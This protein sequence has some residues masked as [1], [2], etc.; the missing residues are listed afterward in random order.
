MISLEWKTAWCNLYLYSAV[1]QC[2][3][4]SCYLLLLNAVFPCAGT[5]GRRRRGG[6][7]IHLR[8]L[9]DDGKEQLATWR[10]QLRADPGLQP[11][12]KIR[13]AIVGLENP[14]AREAGIL[15]AIILQQVARSGKNVNTASASDLC[16]CARGTLV[17]LSQNPDRRTFTSSDGLNRALTTGTS[18]VH[19]GQWRAVVPREL[20]YMQGHPRSTMVPTEMSS[21]SLRALAGEG[22]ALP[23]LGLCLWV[24]YLLK[25]YPEHVESR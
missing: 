19:L 1:L 15:N 5:L 2:R 24:Q 17:D 22:I 13:R 7:R 9:R 14:T 10:A 11:L 23:C 21:R 6:E 16:H 12:K 8:R 18:A 20:L 25:G 3:S 4:G